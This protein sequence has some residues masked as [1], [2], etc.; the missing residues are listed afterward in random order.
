[1]NELIE[2]NGAKIE[3]A[4]FEENVR[5]A[6]HYE[7][8]CLGSTDLEDH[9]HCMICNIAISGLKKSEERI[10]KSKGGWLCGYCHDQ[11]VKR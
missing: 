6:N 3:R 7:W 11:Y 5:E 10:Y 4:Y 9:V 1:M 2:V 8:E